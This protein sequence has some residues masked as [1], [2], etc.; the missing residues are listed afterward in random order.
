[1]AKLKVAFASIAIPVSCTAASSK[2]QGKTAFLWNYALASCQPVLMTQSPE[3]QT[4]DGV[5]LSLIVLVNS[6]LMRAVTAIRVGCL[7]HHR[8]K[9]RMLSH[10]PSEATFHGHY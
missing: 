3:L 7:L 9:M 2:I 10:R 4:E 5:S 1:M 6:L 8:S